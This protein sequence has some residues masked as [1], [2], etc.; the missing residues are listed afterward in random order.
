M[1]AKADMEKLAFDTLLSV[2]NE[3]L[4]LDRQM[5]VLEVTQLGGFTHCARGTVDLHTAVAGLSRRACLM[6]A[7]GNLI[8]CRGCSKGG[9]IGRASCRER[10]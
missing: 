3:E 9:E 5:C 4:S 1:A 8:D 6:Q 7:R 2:N 10:V